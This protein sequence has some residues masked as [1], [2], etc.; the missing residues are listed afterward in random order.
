MYFCSTMAARL[1]PSS[2]DSV[3]RNK[4]TAVS[5]SHF[6]PHT[7]SPSLSLFLSALGPL[8]VAVHVQELQHLAAQ[9]GC[10]R[11][12]EALHVDHQ[13]ALP[14]VLIPGHQVLHPWEGRGQR[15][16]SYLQACS[17]HINNEYACLLKLLYVICINLRMGHCSLYGQF[18]WHSYTVEQTNR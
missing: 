15:G 1:L 13:P 3:H 7:H 10:P 2:P 6:L 5:C 16:G 11:L 14:L 17:L 4:T 8:P 18:M 12:D 9:A